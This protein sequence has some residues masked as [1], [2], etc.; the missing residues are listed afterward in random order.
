MQD[1]TNVTD[2]RSECRSIINGVDEQIVKLL[3]ERNRAVDRIGEFKR[4]NGIAV[5]DGEREKQLLI[6]IA[7][8]AGSDNA[9]D[10]CAVYE[11]ILE[12]S[13]ERQE[14]GK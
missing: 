1:G 8:L 6:R 7:E 2:I 3:C 12:K 11:K 10:I 9:D 14:R 4:E 5:Y 13:R